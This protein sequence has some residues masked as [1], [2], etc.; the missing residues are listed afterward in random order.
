VYY[1]LASYLSIEEDNLTPWGRVN[2][3]MS[4]LGENVLQDDNYE[5]GCSVMGQQMEPFLLGVH[6]SSVGNIS[7][8]L[9]NTLGNCEYQIIRGQVLVLAAMLLLPNFGNIP[10]DPMLSIEHMLSRIP[11]ISCQNCLQ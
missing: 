5:E 7:P 10:Q 2:M 8:Q 11:G 9:E 6:T 1:K 4:F 3:N